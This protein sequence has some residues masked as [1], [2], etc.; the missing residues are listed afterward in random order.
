MPAL[1]TFTIIQGPLV[2][3]EFVFD[4]RTTTL[5]GKENDCQIRFPKDRDHQA[6]SRHHCLLDVNPPD[7]RIRDLAS[8]N[9]TFVNGQLIGK[10]PRDQSPTA[11]FR[12][13]FPEVD[14]KDGDE[15]QLGRQN[16]S[17]LRVHVRVPA[18][19]ATCLAEVAPGETTV[20][21]PSPGHYLC[22]SC[23]QKTLPQQGQEHQLP[24]GLVCVRC[25]KD[26]AQ[27]TNGQRKGD[28]V[29]SA[30]K[31]SLDLVLQRLLDL[32]LSGN[33]ELVAIQGY[34]IVRELGRG[35]MGAV[36]LA[37][38]D[39]TGNE[40]ALK[41]MLPQVAANPWNRDRFLR[42]AANSRP[43]THPNL[44]RLHD[45]GCSQGIF[46]FTMD[47]CS[48]GNAAQLVK[49]RGGPLG[50]HEAVP[51]I[52]QTLAGLEYAHQA[53]IPLVRRADGSYGAGR[54]LVHRDVKPHNIFLSGSGPDQIAKLGD[55]GLAKAFDAAGLSG[56]SA[57]G[58][59]AG[60]PVFMPREQLIN[61]KYA[62]PE[63]D[64]WS[65]A[66]SLYFLL[67]G[68]YPREF[69]GGEDPWQVVLRT[70]AIPI[71]ERN[72]SIPVP[73]A[74]V[75]DMALVDDPEIPFKTAAE[76]RQVLESAL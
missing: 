42:E 13:E 18:T 14:L 6:I 37:C 11:S 29:C 31:G 58:A 62:K 54:G 57:T 51:I 9:G 41:I 26:V 74:Q 44:V 23:Y 61:F 48:G 19:C 47:Y 16:S 7:V 72:P 17:L 21:E 24:R 28:F 5:I 64:V 1:V 66:A 53:E 10:R 35:G 3:R 45:L 15:I 73:L 33:K 22:E 59:L 32:A 76:L 55:Y 50:V 38:H 34:R 30:C 39:T 65:T 70:M 60:T 36:Y 46:F 8:R 69:P 67:T 2:G 12:M 56:M 4:E 68:K 20:S 43:L 40:V 25:G 52:L 71:R 27:E 63:V 75:I 49:Q